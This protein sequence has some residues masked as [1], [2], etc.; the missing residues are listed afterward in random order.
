MVLPEETYKGKIPVFL[1][2]S[3]W[4]LFTDGQQID[5]RLETL[6]IEGDIPP[7]SPRSCRQRNPCCCLPSDT[8]VS[9]AVPD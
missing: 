2:D 6:Q 5:S 9:A 1:N 8:E 3:A 7:Q 4:K